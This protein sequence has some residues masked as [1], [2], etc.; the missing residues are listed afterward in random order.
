MFH[1]YKRRATCDGIRSPLLYGWNKRVCCRERFVI[2]YRQVLWKGLGF[3]DFDGE[4][5]WCGDS[6]FLEWDGSYFIFWGGF[7]HACHWHACFASFPLLC[8][9][10]QWLYGRPAH[11]LKWTSSPLQ[12]SL[13]GL[14]FHFLHGWIFGQKIG[15]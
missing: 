1:P 9:S 11:T 4:A 12:A 10:F 2:P 8:S 15:S 5:V 14:A 7:R 6:L 3:R 13:H